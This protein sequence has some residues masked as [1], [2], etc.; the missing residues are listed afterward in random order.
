[1]NFSQLV[2]H[3]NPDLSRRSLEQNPLFRGASKLFLKSVPEPESS[4]DL[5]ES[6]LQLSRNDSIDVQA[7]DSIQKTVGK[8]M[9]GKEG[10]KYEPNI[11][12]ANM[13]VC[14]DVLNA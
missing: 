12:K 2:F 1:M 14:C 7:V 13:I 4:Q 8:K 3:L 5:K 6:L 9:K 11:V 10:K